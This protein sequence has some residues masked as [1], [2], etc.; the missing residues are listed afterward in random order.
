MKKLLLALVVTTASLLT[1]TSC[2]KEYVTNYLPG[3]SYVYDILSNQWSLI[4]ETNTYIYEQSIPELD[5][6]YFEDGHV[7][8]AISY[9]DNSTTYEIIPAIIDDYSFS[10]SYSVG[11]VRIY[12]EDIGGG[13]TIH[14]PK[15]MITKIVLTDAEIGN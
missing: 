6:R 15:N 10:A 11:V 7:S 14:P 9:D 8:V 13:S 3:S 4:D 2:T 12:A 1:F 5:K